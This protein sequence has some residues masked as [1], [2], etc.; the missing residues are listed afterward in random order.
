MSY[1][2]RAL[3]AQLLEKDA[4]IKVLQHRSRREQQGLRPARSV[5]SISTIATATTTTCS[6]RGKGKEPFESGRSPW[7]AETL[8]LK[9]WQEEGRKGGEVGEKKTGTAAHVF[10]VTRQ[11]ARLLQADASL[12]CAVSKIKPVGLHSPLPATLK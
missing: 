9:E 5:P 1:R 3:H 4:V 10:L 2:I 12:E 11:L 7:V 6:I 8:E